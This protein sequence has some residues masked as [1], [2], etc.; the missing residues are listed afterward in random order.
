VKI[1]VWHWGRRGA[2]PRFARELATALRSLDGIEAALSLP[3]TADILALPDAKPCD[4]PLPTYASAMGLARQYL[5]APAWLGWLDRQLALLRPD[6]AICAMPAMLDHLMFRALDRRGIASVVI[7]HDARPH[8]GDGGIVR[9]AWDRVLLRRA[10]AI[11]V[12]TRHVGTALAP[13]VPSLQLSHPPFPMPRTTPARAHDGPLRVLS[14]GRMRAYKGIDLL[15]RTLALLPVDWDIRVIGAGRVHAD[16]AGARV[17]HRFV[18]EAELPEIF[19]WADVVLL[20]HRAASQSGVAA[21]ALGAGR[22]VVA[23]NVGGLPE[24]LADAPGAMLCPPDPV[25]LAAALRALPA[26]APAP[27]DARRA[28]CAMAADLLAQARAAGLGRTA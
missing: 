14:F 15:A 4:L 27:I 28:W 21:M 2:G 3:A 8:P 1:L 10:G 22:F 9:A 26:E 13:L 24:Q 20:T 23:T 17:E 7:A 25:S 16:L 12:L 11:A 5:N 19:A 6:F 18:P